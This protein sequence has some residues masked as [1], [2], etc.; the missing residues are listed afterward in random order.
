M[1]ITP[2]QI[3]SYVLCP[4]QYSLSR[5]KPKIQTPASPQSVLGEAIHDAI[6]RFLYQILNNN[7]RMKKTRA[8]RLVERKNDTYFYQSVGSF[9][10]FSAGLIIESLEGESSQSKLIRNKRKIRWPENA[11]SD[12]IVELKKRFFLMGLAMLR[13]YYLKNLGKPAPFLRE[14]LLRI[15]LAKEICPGLVLSGRIDQARRNSRGQ[16]YIPDLKTGF[17]QFERELSQAQ[18]GNTVILT[19]L[20]TDPQLDAYWLLYERIFREPPYRVGFYYLKTGKT[21]FTE[22]TQDQID[23]FLATIRHILVAGEHENFP[24]FG[25]DRKICRYCDYRDHCKHFRSAKRAKILTIEEIEEGLPDTDRLEDQLA[26]ELQDIK[27]QELKLKL[28]AR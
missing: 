11:T 13:D 9:L 28:R 19:P 5:Q 7:L 16:V 6:N 27:Y 20:E 17:D 3:K 1:I 25:L 21:Y 24:P 10:R 14:E 12:Q 26:E 23:Q 18:E 4:H 15:S 22:R 8:R 2:S